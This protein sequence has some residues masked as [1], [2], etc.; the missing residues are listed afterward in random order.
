MAA[1]SYRPDVLAPWK[2]SGI[3]AHEKVGAGR[4]GDGNGGDGGWPSAPSAAPSRSA[5]QRA[6]CIAAVACKRRSCADDVE[7]GAWLRRSGR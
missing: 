5:A 7:G 4:A 1:A 2:A 6:R 3:V